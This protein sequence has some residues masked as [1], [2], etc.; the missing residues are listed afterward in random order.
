M[1]KDLYF[2]QNTFR[3]MIVLKHMYLNVY[4]LFVFE[5]MCM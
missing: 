4:I 5:V 3:N 1:L 2:V